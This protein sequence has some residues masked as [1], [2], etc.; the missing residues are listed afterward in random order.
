MIQPVTKVV[1]GRNRTARLSDIGCAVTPATKEVAAGRDSSRTT[2]RKRVSTAIT[3]VVHVKHAVYRE[4][5]RYPETFNG[6]IVGTH[7][8]PCQNVKGSEGSRSANR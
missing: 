4:T 3:P 7:L 2:N 1:D 6:G 5:W 8:P